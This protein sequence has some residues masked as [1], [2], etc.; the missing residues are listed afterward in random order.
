M[1]AIDQV[2]AHFSNQQV[3]LIEVPEWAGDDGQPLMIY[4]KPLTL[5]EKQKL[6]AYAQNGGE[7]EILV[8]TLIMKAEDAQGNKLFTVEHKH[9]LMNSADPDV[10]GRVAREITRARTEE[11][12]EKK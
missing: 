4:A 9:S 1:S 7:L 3:R 6:R 10:V 12:L 2:K 8:Y 5:T 11:E